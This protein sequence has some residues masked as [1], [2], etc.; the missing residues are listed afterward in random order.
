MYAEHTTALFFLVRQTDLL[1]LR[2]HS[3]QLFVSPSSDTQRNGLAKLRGM[4]H[5][6][7]KTWFTF[8]F[9]SHRRPQIADYVVQYSYIREIRTISPPRR[10]EK[11]PPRGE[12][13][14]TG[15]SGKKRCPRSLTPTNECSS[16][17][18]RA[19]VNRPRIVGKQRAQQF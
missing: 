14:K 13:P 9:C 1:R 17:G 12:N 6:F 18:P 7:P 16:K 2:F 11:V 19:N 3:L 4:A 10:T 8:D 15:R 5:F